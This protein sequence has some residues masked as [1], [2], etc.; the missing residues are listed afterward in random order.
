MNDEST[1]SNALRC[2]W[3]EEEVD[4]T[5][6]QLSDATGCSQATIT[7][8]VEQGVLEPQG[9]GPGAWRFAGSSLRRTRVALRLIS[10]LEV[11]P[12]GAA[13]ALELLEQIDRLQ[14][15]SPSTSRH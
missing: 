15:A 5:L 11:N 9:D 7:D 10:E 3:V 6:G 4:M 14:V 12:A 1:M 2:E 8:L 13:V